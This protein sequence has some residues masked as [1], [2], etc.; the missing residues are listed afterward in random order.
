MND[1]PDFWASAPEL[2]RAEVP[3]NFRGKQYLGHM[4]APAEHVGPRPLVLVIHN[5]QG[6]KYFDIDVAEYMAR[7][8]Y[9]GLAIDVYGD[10]I[11]PQER[12]WPTNPDE[13]PHHLTKAFEAMVSLDHDHEFFRA[14]LAAWLQVGKELAPVDQSLTPAAIGYCFGGV[15]VLEAVRGGLDLSGVVSFHGLLQTGEDTSPGSVGVKRP[16][17][18]PCANNYNTQTLVQ[19]E[20]GAKDHLV[21]D[22]HRA[23]F[24]EEMDQAGVQ[25]SFHDYADTPHGFALPTSL[26]GPGHLHDRADRRSTMNMLNLFR[27]VFPDVPQNAVSHNA[28][29][30]SIP[31]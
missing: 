4:V 28:A 15:A 21:N 26:G 22:D 17:L 11:S 6:L 23:R 9:V 5:Y 3:L 27:E 12:L 29:G 24:Y 2:Q 16:T 10:M 19:I 14:M 1:S 30:T 13:L 25:W 31:G 8:G 18:K 7:L 20:N